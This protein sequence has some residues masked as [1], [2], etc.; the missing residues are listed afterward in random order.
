MH[1]WL[2]CSGG[3]TASSVA[4]SAAIEGTLTI[5]AG[6][7]EELVGPLIQRFEDATGVDVQ[8]NYAGTTDLAAT[9]LEEGEASPAD[10]FF[11][12]DAGA[13]GLRFDPQWHSRRRGAST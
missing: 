13:L 4:P 11:A 9:L 10:V 5:Y 6:R 1:R 7:S 8:V 3:S 2:R 12:Q